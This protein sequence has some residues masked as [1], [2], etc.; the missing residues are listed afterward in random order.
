MSHYIA[1][2]FR[3]NATNEA[4]FRIL[5]EDE[6]P[7]IPSEGVIEVDG[8]Y[9][10][11]NTIAEAKS[12]SS[13]NGY[14][15]VNIGSDTYYAP[16]G[17]EFYGGNYPDSATQVCGGIRNVQDSYWQKIF[18]TNFI[19]F[20]PAD[21][22]RV[23][24]NHNLL[25]KVPSGRSHYA[26]NANNEAGVSGRSNFGS[27]QVHSRSD[28]ILWIG[29]K[30]NDG[31][32][33]M[34]QLI[35]QRSRDGQRYYSEFETWFDGHIEDAPLQSN[36]NVKLKSALEFGYD[37]NGEKYLKHPLEDDRLNGYW[38]GILEHF[39]RNKERHTSIYR[40]NLEAPTFAD[41]IK[42]G[43]DVYNLMLAH[44]PYLK[45]A[46]FEN[47]DGINSQIRLRAVIIDAGEDDDEA[48]IATDVQNFVNSFRE[49]IGIASLPI[50]YVQRDLYSDNFEVYNNIAD[51]LSNFYYHTHRS[52]SGELRDEIDE[53]IE[54]AKVV[55]PYI[56]R[57]FDIEA[58][59][60]VLLIDFSNPIT[61]ENFQENETLF[62]LAASAT[63]RE[64]LSVS[65]FPYREE[66]QEPQLIPDINGF[67][68][69]RSQFG[70]LSHSTTEL[71]GGQ[72]FAD[73]NMFFV[74]KTYSANRN[75][76]YI[77]SG[78]T[79][80]LSHFLWENDVAYFDFGQNL[81]SQ[82]LSTR[83]IQVNEPVILGISYNNNGSNSKITLSV[84]GSLSTKTHATPID[85][86]VGHTFHL[87][88]LSSFDGNDNWNFADFSMAEWI[89]TTEELSL[90]EF[91][92]IEGYLSHKYNISLEDGHPFNNK[93]P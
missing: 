42:Q 8:H 4:E 61:Q 2:K 20:H 59:N 16:E 5:K 44:V 63:Q 27:V 62:N 29:K 28:L 36:V 6:L 82:R 23:G 18:R 81:F 54:L 41:D 50:F 31:L 58:Y 26:V 56:Q 10:L 52:L 1:V 49:D 15:E 66:E 57:P 92:T 14:V 87:G 47:T 88:G 73:F 9:P 86:N 64:V 72:T 83:D 74:I 46:M 77:T 21:R 78:G 76:F 37:E 89:V 40:Y 68:C 79:R 90:K 84:N 69:L 60:P 48:T 67:T 85:L 70:N 71:F 38:L 39:S 32:D 25:V 24:D 30:G 91:Q 65:S 43:S 3:D 35:D 55:L 93:R 11:Y 17:E 51:G 53:G 7:V 45:T 22:S 33:D 34:S 80:F 19:D 13:V 12:A 75:Y